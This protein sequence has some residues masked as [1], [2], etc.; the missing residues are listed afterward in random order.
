MRGQLSRVAKGK[1][2]GG[3]APYGYDLACLDGDGRLT[4]TV[5]FLGNGDRE[6]RG[7]DGLLQ[8]IVRRGAPM[9]A[10]SGV[11]SVRPGPCWSVAPGRWSS[12]Q[13]ALPAPGNSTERISFSTL[14]RAPS[15][16]S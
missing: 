12:W 16:C 1:W 14:R 10:A 7:H 13:E 9:P 8:E 2:C 11:P 5:R 4:R 15:G 3:R 6:V